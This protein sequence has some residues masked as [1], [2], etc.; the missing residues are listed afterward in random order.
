MKFSY[1]LITIVSL[2]NFNMAQLSI[3]SAPQSIIKGLNKNVPIFTTPSFDTQE[4]IEQD[5]LDLEQNI[6]YRF[7]YNI[8]TDIN[9][10][11]YA[12]CDTLDNGDKVFRLKISSPEAYSINFIFN[13]FYLLEG[14][15]LFIYNNDYSDQL[16]AFT[17]RNNKSYNR[18]STSQI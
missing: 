7:G 17:Y 9:F 2:V 13:N 18:F 11:D 12:V 15:E 16:G 3:D 5:I 1:L 6:P 10:F 14:S 4:L 8:S